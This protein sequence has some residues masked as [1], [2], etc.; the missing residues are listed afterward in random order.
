[1]N[2]DNKCRSSTT[3]E[4]LGEMTKTN[5]PEEIQLDSDVDTDEEKEAEGEC[6]TVFVVHTV[7]TYFFA[8]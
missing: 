1:V 2:F 5:N 4:E 6:V 8:K 3:A 7:L